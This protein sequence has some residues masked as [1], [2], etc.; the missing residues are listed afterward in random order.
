[1]QKRSRT[2]LLKRALFGSK[3]GRASG[4]KSDCVSYSCCAYCLRKEA[5]KKKKTPRR[6]GME[7]SSWAWRGGGSLYNIDSGGRPWPARGWIRR[8]WAPIKAQTWTIFMFANSGLGRRAGL[9]VPG[10]IASGP[11]RPAPRPRS[12]QNQRNV[13]DVCA[14]SAFFCQA[15]IRLNELRAVHGQPESASVCCPGCLWG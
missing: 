2:K 8:M 15:Q 4:S 10:A 13:V 6:G 9:R 1:M 7:H 14:L 3:L 12:E 5:T 11:Q